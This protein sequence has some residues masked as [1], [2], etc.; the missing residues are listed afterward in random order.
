MSHHRGHGHHNPSLGHLV[1]DALGLNHHHHHGHHNGGYVQPVVMAQ[2]GYVAPMQPMGYAP[3]QPMVY[4]M[5]NNYYGHH[6]HHGH[7]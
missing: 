7:H 4:P 5:N 2:P 1:G 3:V 6:G